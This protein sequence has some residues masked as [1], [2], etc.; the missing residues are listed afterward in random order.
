M[1]NQIRIDMKYSVI[2][3]VYN[4][5]KTIERCI[6]S[7]LVQKRN[8]AEI[9][10]VNDGSTDAT[11]EILS[12]YAAEYK[13]I[14]LI[15]QKNSGVS[16]ARNAGIERASGNYITFVDSDDYVSENYFSAL[17]EMEKQADADL[18]MFSSNTVGGQE[19][20]ESA[21][22]H[23]ME[24]MNDTGT[25]ME[26]LLSSRKIM[27]PWNKRFKREIIIANGIRFIRQFQTGEDFNFCLE[28]ML[29]CHSISVSC[30]KLYNV[31]ISDK[32]SLSRKYRPG[33][34][35][36]LE[37]V[38]KNAADL[39]SKSSLDLKEKERLLCIT[40]YLFI[41]NVF[42]CIAEEFKANK[43][44]YRSMKKDIAD[45]YK[46]FRTPLC[47]KGTYC[48][49]IHRGLRTFVYRR[50]ILPI[51]GITLIA[52]GKKFAKYMEA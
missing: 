43:P 8:D 39:I 36:Q 25:K 31:D 44:N 17:D 15:K 32:T 28:Y 26:L 47:S 52:K 12:R 10:V 24:R 2:I 40:D 1:S 20:D 42:T 33:L 29:N 48:N 16:A 46:R 45:I 11:E 3:P 27:S 14:L 37:K 6:Q 23:Q 35:L 38:F 22:Y 9:I 34:A 19:A 41:K 18:L 21:L 4:S 49:V 30:E 50:C 7:L 5:E 13:N 51:Y